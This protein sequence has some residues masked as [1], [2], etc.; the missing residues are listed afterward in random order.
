MFSCVLDPPNFNSNNSDSD[1]DPHPHCV[2]PGYSIIMHMVFSIQTTTTSSSSSTQTIS[3]S[4][5]DFFESISLQRCPRYY[6]DSLFPPVTALSSKFSFPTFNSRPGDHDTTTL[7]TMSTLT[8]RKVDESSEM[9][10][11]VISRYSI[12]PTTSVYTKKEGEKR[13]YR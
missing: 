8:N 7:A 13:K 10:S 12:V 9:H 4:N 1:L 3:G 6:T 2:Q 5:T 11:Q